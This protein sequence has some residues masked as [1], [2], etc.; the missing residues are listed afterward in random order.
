VTAVPKLA[1]RLVVAPLILLVEA[2][3]VA[4]SPLLALIAAV[5]SPLVGGWRA[6]RAL[7]IAVDYAARH[8]A[9]TAACAGLWVASGFGRHVRSG[10]MQRA[11]YGVLR[12]FVGG[13]H[14]RMT[15]LAG[16][17]VQTTPDSEAAERALSAK[18]TPVVVLSRHAGEGDSLLVLHALLCRHDRRPRVVLHE[19]LRLDP[20]IDMLGHRLPNRFVDPRGG[21]T[22]GEIAAM[23]SDLGDGDALLIF[24]EGGNF[25]HSRR[26][27]GIERLEQAGHAEEAAWAR[28]M[29]HVAA[30]RP[31]GA[32]AAIEAAP[33][34]DVIFLGHVGVPA[35]MREAWRRLATPGQNIEVRLWI[36]CAEDVP[37]GKD[38][39]IDWLFGWWRT[40]DAWVDER[41]R[42]PGAPAA[43]AVRRPG[44]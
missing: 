7:A 20:L 43:E 2:A 17:D 26:R 1:R 44:G 8:L 9:S 37:T 16:V 34:A 35:G 31:G 24:P 19:A 32:L 11:H 42:P 27:R 22:E 41:Q 33:G 5:L 15:R 10:R 13:I 14:R 18:R 12:W 4:L 28:E 40:I 29:R 3:L 30:P 36:E 6:L 25:S 23:A 21:D 39:Q 38:A